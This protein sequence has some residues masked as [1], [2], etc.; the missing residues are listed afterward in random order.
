MALTLF[1]PE[2]TKESDMATDVPINFKINDRLANILGRA[3]VITDKSKSEIIRT[4]ILLSISTVIA[5]PALCN[6]V[7]VEHFSDKNIMEIQK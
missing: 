5:N 1:A 2:S 4:C 3:T 7:Q 6:M